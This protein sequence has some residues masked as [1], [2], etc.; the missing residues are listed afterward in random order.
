MDRHRADV[1]LACHFGRGGEPR[2]CVQFP[3]SNGSFNRG[4][5]RNPAHLLCPVRIGFSRSLV[6]GF[7]KR[8]RHD[9]S[10]LSGASGFILRCAL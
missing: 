6:I 3:S 5:D 10:S 1:P 2:S 8:F 4:G 7:V 9:L